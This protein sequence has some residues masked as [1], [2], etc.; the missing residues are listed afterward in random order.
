MLSQLTDIRLYVLTCKHEQAHTQAHRR[1]HV[2]SG[3]GELNLSD[4]LWNVCG[5]R[6]VSGASSLKFQRRWRSQQTASCSIAFFT[7]G[8]SHLA[9]L[10]Y[11]IR[12]HGELTPHL[13]VFQPLQPCFDQKKSE[14]I[15]SENKNKE[16]GRMKENLSLIQTLLVFLWA[17]CDKLVLKSSS[18][19]TAQHLAHFFFKIWNYGWHPAVSR[20]MF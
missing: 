5:L 18:V 6:H 13:L 19:W 9:T 17:V 15:I 8:H 1:K 3:E 10:R 12:P 16:L 2:L 4:F 20:N 7:W 14:E 11:S